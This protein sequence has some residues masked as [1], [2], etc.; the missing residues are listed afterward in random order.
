MVEDY[1]HGN[2]SVPNNDREEIRKRN[3]AAAMAG[4]YAMVFG[5]DIA[6]S[7]ESWLT[8]CRILQTF[9]EET[10]FNQMI[11]NDLLA[12]GETNYVLANESYDYIIYS[13]KA[14]NNLGIKNLDNGNY[15]LRWLDCESGKEIIQKDM[16][17][18]SGDQKWDKPST[19]GNEVVLYLH[20][21]DRRPD[22]KM[23]TTI[24]KDIDE[25]HKTTNSSP[26]ATSETI[27]VE[28]NS[29][30][31]IQLTYKDADGGPGPYTITI[32]EFPEHG[33]MSGTGNDRYYVPDQDY[34]GKDQF[35]WKVND[36]LD[37]S[38]VT[39][40]DLIID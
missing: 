11:P 26:I 2:V 40:I 29:K 19:F 15:M 13:S 33:T 18:A 12:Y 22:I 35:F 31:Y 30:R 28:K 39:K 14:N 3:W 1:V 9:F 20:R 5:M 23:V 6:N 8:D 24:A 25:S 27:R 34:S 17:L 37:D 4:S 36:G 16:A 10:H 32:T 7:P 38:K 21:K